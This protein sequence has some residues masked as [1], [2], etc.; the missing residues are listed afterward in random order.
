MM[1][2]QSFFYNDNFN[3]LLFD[4][5]S[6]FLSIILLLITVSYCIS[7]AYFAKEMRR[8]IALLIF[9]S[10]PFVFSIVKRLQAKKVIAFVAYGSYP[11]YLLHMIVINRVN[12]LAAQ[13]HVLSS[14]KSWIAVG[15]LSFLSS[16]ALA[17]GTQKGYDWIIASIR[18]RN[19]SAIQI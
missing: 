8:L 16:L 2:A 19:N 1:I 18:N 5:R 15:I 7:N 4:R 3:K 12:I 17:Y 9:L 14:Y 11:F 13:T 6:S 10:L